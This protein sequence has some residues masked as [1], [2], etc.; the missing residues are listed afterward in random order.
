[1][2][3]RFRNR[4]HGGELSNREV[5]AQA[6]ADDQD[7]IAQRSRPRSAASAHV[8][9]RTLQLAHE[10]LKLCGRETCCVRESLGEVGHEVVMS[11]LRGR[12]CRGIDV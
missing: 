9:M 5:G 1:M 3:L 4:E 7:T 11:E 12:I 2:H 10:E 8:G 6:G